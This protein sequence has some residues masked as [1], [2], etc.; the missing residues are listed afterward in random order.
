MSKRKK[1]LV[2]DDEETIA[3]VIHDFL[4]EQGYVVHIAYNGTDGIQMAATEQPDVVILDVELPDM[5]GFEVCK[6]MREISN[7]RNTPIVMLTVRSA[8]ADELAGLQAGA[9]DYMTKPFKP[10]RLLA[11]IQT[12]IERNLREL[13]ANPLTHLP[14]NVSILEELERRISRKAPFAV[15]YMDL[16]NF[17]AF[18]DRYSFLRGDEVIKLTSDILLKCVGSN[19]KA[20][21]FLGHVGGDDFVAIIDPAD[22]DEVSKAIISNFDGNITQL[23]DEE[24]RKRGYIQTVDRLGNQ[25]KLPLMGIAIAVVSNA[26][27]TFSHPGEL[28]LVAGDL[29]KWAKSKGT[30]AYVVDRRAG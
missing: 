5:S 11:R 9:D 22:V 20:G 19:G 12:A 29:K 24:D 13:D 30:S 21:R 23:Y 16:N 18:N 4:E 15:L 6:K 27:R 17:K 1:V 14:G 26:A 3:Q 10:A 25:V 8:E 2:V 7:L 28:S